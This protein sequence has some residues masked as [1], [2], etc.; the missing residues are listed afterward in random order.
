MS[1]FTVTNPEALL[2]A[3]D[4]PVARIADEL[5]S[6]ARTL[7]P[8]RTGTLA[9]GWT[10]R[11]GGSGRRDVVN[12]VRYAPFVEYGTRRT[13]PVAMMGRARAQIEGRYGAR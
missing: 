12:Q 13:A 7:T 2:E 11:R 6:T 5:A 10:V 8:R 1:T 9:A 4:E 3:V